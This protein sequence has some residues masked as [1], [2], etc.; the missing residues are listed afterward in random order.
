M[1]KE[2]PSTHHIPVMRDEVVEVLR[3]SNGGVFLD[4]TCGGGG[5]ARALL[6][7]NPNNAV[8]GIDRDAAAVSRVESLTTKF[9]GRF[10]ISHS[11]FSEVQTVVG[12]Q[13][14]DGVLADLGMSTDQLK[15]GR[16]FSFVDTE[17][18]D[19]RMDT[20]C[21][22]SAHEFLN[23]ASERD[24]FLALARGGIG[25]N[26][27][28]IAKLIVRNREISSAK[29]LADLI[30]GTRLGKSGEGRSHPATVVFQAIRMHINRELEQIEALLSVAPTV[31]KS[32]GRL[33]VITFHSVEDRLVTKRLRSWES[34]DS[35]PASWRGAVQARS[36]GSM[37]TKKAIVPSE[38][39]IAINPASR[40]A[41]LRVFEF[42][43]HQEN[44][45]VRMK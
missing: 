3:G 23:T 37:V 17:Q 19:M 38:E 16:G 21:G 24:I 31:V 29:Q 36:L 2:N 8:Y 35:A 40:S 13:Q 22:E 25:S 11:P 45:S 15:E 12:K 18:L 26:A 6:E 30:R 4:C 10:F 9:A 7:A 41:K 20:S 14:F 33:A 39:E 44:F 27:K 5:H 42:A 43:A 34:G 32:G 28:A 1:S